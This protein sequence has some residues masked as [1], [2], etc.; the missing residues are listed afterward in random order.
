MSRQHS[1]YNFRLPEETLQKFKAESAKEKRSTTAQLN[2][3]IEE[4][5]AKRQNQS[6]KA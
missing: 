3:I 2:M 6:A 1:Q 5:L 4:W